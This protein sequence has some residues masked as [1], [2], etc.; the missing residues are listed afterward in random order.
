MGEA[1]ETLSTKLGLDT[2][3]FKTGIAGVNREMRVVE[4]GFRASAAALGDWAN[5][6]SGM[7]QRLAALTQKIDLQKMKVAALVEEQARLAAEFGANSIQAQD[8]QIRVNKATEELGNMT[9]E[10]A[11][12]Q[13]SL[14]EMKTSEADAATSAEDL[15][16]KVQDA[17]NKT[18]DAKGKVMSFSDV[19]GGLKTVALAAVGA[20][21]GIGVAAAGLVLALGGL[22]L[23][24]ATA[25]DE[26]V[27]LSQ[28]S[29]IGVERLQELAY[30]GDQVGTSQETIVGSMTKLTRN[31]GTASKQVEDYNAKL[32]EAEAAGT[33]LADVTMGDAA[34]AF[35]E[36]GISVTDA[37]GNLRDSEDVFNEAITALGDIENATERDTLSMALFGKSAQELNPLIEAGADQIAALS[38]EANDMGAVMG[39][40]SVNALAGMADTVDSVKASFGGLL[41]NLAVMVLPGFQGFASAV[42]QMMLNLVAY[43]QTPEFQQFA[44]DIG[45]AFASLGMW[46]QTN[47]PIAIAAFSVFW[48]TTLLP[49]LT[50]VWAWMT[51]SLFPAL[52]TLWTWLATN[53]PP[54]I[55]ALAAFWTGTLQPALT[56]VWA[57]M[58]TSLFPALQTLWTW[59]ATNIP[60]VIVAL[61]AFWTGTLQPALTSVWAWMTTSLFPTLTTLWT[62][63]GTTLT[64]A[65]TSLAAFWQT[66]LLPA[67]TAVWN[68]ITTNVLPL[69]LSLTELGITAMGV[70]LTA[71][72]GIWENT[73][74]PALKTVWEY[75][76][77]NLFPIFE[78]IGGFL[79]KT[80]TDTLNA[81]VDG[82]L[83]NLS[84]AFGGI[85]QAIQDAISWISDLTTKLKEIKLPGW[86][87]PGSPTPWEIG[88]RGVN[89]AM[90]TLNSQGLSSMSNE[91]E[92]Y[93]SAYAMPG[94][95][96][97]MGA[98]QP[99]AA[100]IT[101]QL[102]G[103]II[104]NDMD[105][106]VVAYRVAQKIQE[107][108]RS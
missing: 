76:D 83:G 7:E 2:T 13:T 74:Y 37:N 28:K 30:V 60:P 48:T 70:A 86:M 16:S 58:T 72:Q 82:P 10:A 22:V 92:N 90:R 88:L 75:L 26:L 24:S 101:V 66:T 80:F 47:L 85:S 5:Q 51:T 91:L 97:G 11:D 55:V 69:F 104:N 34:A 100:P 15:G 33:D 38:Q 41:G 12:T 36:L 39:E 57:W 52:Q 62:W 68:F 25:A 95:A 20:L 65:L 87:T 35:Q 98:M 19:L 3:D 21:V 49:A 17:G 14:D 71:L 31:M 32:A 63:L 1:I 27:V 78:E 45:A 18:D 43:L 6:A 23:N 56:A 96:D 67:I 94:M 103:T 102:N 108:R 42:Q 106:E 99:A 9:V 59:L 73:L 84:G 105:I 53:I 8:M 61:A 89:S 50:A 107:R 79:D 93:R 46:L 4:S 81:V 54:V 40:D 77:A 29:G 44:A 64:T